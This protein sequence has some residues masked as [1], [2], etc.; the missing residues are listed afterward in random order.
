MPYLVLI[1]VFPP[2]EESTWESRV[3]GILTNLIPLL[4]I[5]A[6]KPDTSPVIP[7]PIAIKQSFLLKFLFKR[8]DKILSIL[9]WFLFFSYARK[10]Y[11]ITFFD[12]KEFKI[13]LICFFGTLL[14]TTI[15]HFLKFLLIFFRESP[16]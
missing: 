2:I 5:L 14:S 12:D 3:V 8:I 1:P 10:E 6:A 16:C 9:F 15:K 13:L 7:P 11:V 4:K